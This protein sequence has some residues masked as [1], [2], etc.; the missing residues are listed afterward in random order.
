MAK[1]ESAAAF[2]A[3]DISPGVFHLLCMDC[4]W[5]V[6]FSKP[7]SNFRSSKWPATSS[8]KRLWG[9]PGIPGSAVVPVPRRHAAR[10]FSLGTAPGACLWFCLPC[11]PKLCCQEAFVE[12]A[13]PPRC[14]PWSPFPSIG[15]PPDRHL[16]FLH[17]VAF[18]FFPSCKSKGFS[19][20]GLMP[21]FS[22]SALTLTLSPSPTFWDVFTPWNPGCTSN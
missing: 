14:S 16:L 17:P 18:F 10:F 4:V 5:K 12:M 6:C 15:F 9:A 2:Q 1:V 19:H 7:P 22:S 3:R 20:R 8:P 13:S 11:M 21:G